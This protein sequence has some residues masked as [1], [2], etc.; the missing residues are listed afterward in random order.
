MA[1][2]DCRGLRR[3]GGLALGFEGPASADAIVSGVIERLT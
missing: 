3:G 2:S 1:S